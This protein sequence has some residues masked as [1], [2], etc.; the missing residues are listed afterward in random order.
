MVMFGLILFLLNCPR[1]DRAF[2]ET[3]FLHEN[4]DFV[5]SLL[6]NP[7]SDGPPM[8]DIK[9][10]EFIEKLH[11]LTRTHISASHTP[12]GNRARGG[13][14]E[15]Q[16]STDETSPP[17][18]FA[19]EAMAAYPGLLLNGT[20]RLNYDIFIS[21]LNP[22]GGFPWAKNLGGDYDYGIS[23]TTDSSSNIYTT[24]DFRGTVDFD[25][26]P[27]RDDNLIGVSSNDTL[28]GGPSNN[29]IDGLQGDDWLYGGK[30]NDTLIGQQGNDVLFGAQG[31]DSLDGGIGNDTLLGGRGND[32]LFGGENDDVLDGGIGADSL[33]G[34][35]N[36]TLYGGVGNDTLN[37]AE[38]DNFLVLVRIYLLSV[39]PTVLMLL[40][41][42][43]RD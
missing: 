42:S 32:T 43:R 8:S 37:G 10:F 31:D 15:L 12:T 34:I 6:R 39:K 13:D 17:L 28:F 35:G 11:Q 3:G 23:I 19:P 36:D 26:G 16:V 27:G 24:G 29:Y 40:L 7:V 21:K 18:A 30:G 33:N 9:G 2:L 20:P 4:L 41:I 14:W 25:P 1:R 22:D 5:S 38:G